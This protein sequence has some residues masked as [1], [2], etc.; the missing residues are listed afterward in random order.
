VLVKFLE[1][2]SRV[3]VF[4]LDG[5]GRILESNGGMERLFD[6]PLSRPGER[7]LFDF[8]LPENR[9]QVEGIIKALLVHGPHPEECL[10]R[11][12]T[13]NFRVASSAVHTMACFFSLCKGR[14]SFIAEPRRMSDSEVIIRMTDLNNELA[15]LW[16]ELTRK[17]VELEKANETIGRLLNTDVLT[18]IPNRRALEQFIADRFALEMERPFSLV[19]ADIDHFKKVND[20]YGHHAGDVVLASVGEILSGQTRSKDMAGRYG[21]EEFL[22]AMPR[23]GLKEAAEIAERIRAEVEKSVVG[24]ERL[25]I[26]ASFGVAEAKGDENWESLVRRA[27]EALYLA[28][29]SGRNNV[30]ISSW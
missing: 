4:S 18:G 3:A 26:T 13:L 22:V 19:M 9:E 27:D 28:K 17:N 5:D 7:L 20:T 30:A 25:R 29:D 21:G 15:N 23:T 1:T 2:E 12:A 16:R 8:L 6:I 24:E 14:I 11:K 10:F